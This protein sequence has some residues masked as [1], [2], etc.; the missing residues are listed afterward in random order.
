MGHHPSLARRL[1]VELLPLWALVLAL[2]CGAKTGLQVPDSGEQSVLDASLD[3]GVDAGPCYEVPVDGG[4]LDVA[5]EVRAEIGRAD[6]LLLIDTTTSMDQ[7]IDQISARLRDR[8]VPAIAE[9]IPDS[10]LGV[11][12]FADFPVNPYGSPGR[13]TPFTLHLAMTS[14]MADVQAAVNSLGSSNGADQ[15]EA[16]IEALYQTATGAGLGAYVAPSEGCPMGG[17][18]YPCFRRDALPVVLLFT[19]APM[20]NGPSGRHRY[21]G[22]LSP[23]AHSYEATIRELNRLGVRVIGFD[24]GGGN[25]RADLEAVARA[26]NAVDASGAPLVYEIGTNGERLSTG[27]VDAVRTFASTAVFDID[28]VALDPDPADG[29]DVTALVRE[30]IP[31]AADPPMGVREIDRVAGV[32]RGVRAG[33]RV[34]F[35]IVLANELITPGP[36]PVVLRL[37]LVFRGDGRTRL[38]SR[39][40]QIVIPAIDGSGC[41]SASP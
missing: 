14:S 8:I 21:G 31:L 25:G 22:A 30:I 36:E 16:Q 32:F 20:H 24:S 4:P 23:P 1:G 6:V 10:R 35:R 28:A 37:E 27:V 34:S 11:A 17:T 41:I 15:P 3:A 2:G 40:L 7:E 12:S 13:D 26:T 29:V 18:G 33:T 19:D 5:M 9:A 38:A 39:I